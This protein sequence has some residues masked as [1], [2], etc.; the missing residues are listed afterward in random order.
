MKVVNLK[1]NHMKNPLG[2]ELETPTVS[3]QVI[4][5]HSKMQTKAQV[6]V[7]KDP[8]FTSVIFTSDANA[9]I[10]HIGYELPIS[11]EPNTRYFWRVTVW[12]NA[13]EI[14]TSE[15]AWF[16]TAKLAQ[17]WQAK[18]IESTHQSDYTPVFGK[19]VA[20]KNKPIA[21]ARAYICGLGLYELYINQ[22]KAGDEYLAPGCNAYDSWLQYQTYDITTLLTSTQNNIQVLMGDG[23][24]MGRFGFNTP[25]KTQHYGDKHQLIAEFVV[26]YTDGTQDT[27]LTD[28]SWL[29]KDSTIR[30]NSIYDGES[31]HANHESALFPCKLADQQD[32]ARLQARRSPMVRI[33]EQLSPIATSLNANGQL[34]L[35]FGQNMVG[36]V[37]INKVLPKSATLSLEF[38]EC[39]QDGDIYTENLRSAKT[40]FTYE[41]DG[42]T[43]HIRPH[44]TFF[45]F[46]YVRVTCST[47]L[48]PDAF[49][50]C[51]IY[52]DLEQTGSIETD[53]PLINQFFENVLRSQKGNFLDVPTDCPQ[54]D[55]RMGWTGDIQ[56]FAGTACY[57]MDVYAFLNKFLIDLA[58]EQAKLNGSVPFVV[59]MFDVKEAG[60]SGWGDAATVLPW[61]LWEHY[62][63]IKILKQ[64]Y[65]S[66]KTWV[67]FITAQVEK[68]NGDSYLWD[69]GF[70]FG[71]WLA[72][73]NEPN[74]KSFKGK[75]EDKFIA[76]IYFHY[77]ASIV[78]KAAEILGLKNDAIDY[79]KLSSH[80]L[81]DLR[82]EYVTK[83]GRLALDTQTGFV[84]AIMFD[85]VPAEYKD[86]VATDFVKRLKRDD[87]K[88]K[89]GFI[90]TPYMCQALTK[91]GLH[92]IAV[93]LFTNTTC[94]G[95]LYPVTKGATT[96]WERWDSVLDD[97]N[98]NPQSSMNS[99]N[100]YAFGSV[101]E[102]LYRSLFG[103]IPTNDA[104]GF[105]HVVMS[106]KPHYKFK[107]ANMRYNAIAGE[108]QIDW[109][110]TENG[111]LCFNVTVPFNCEA[112]LI[113]PD[114]KHEEINCNISLANA[115]QKQTD[116]IV[117]LNAGNYQFKY[118]PTKEY[119]K[120]YDIHVSLNQLM[121][122]SET[123][124]ILEKHIPDIIHLPFIKIMANE[125]LA[126]ISKKP[127]FKYEHSI[128]DVLNNELNQYKIN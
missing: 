5:C 31:I 58:K 30:T 71:D 22:Q 45:G 67:D 81:N 114:A 90:G 35:D 44:F 43:A 84:L 19:Q 37:E 88:I 126:D 125:S 107:K 17:P 64:Q 116:V 23:W 82:N 16:E 50:A 79:H 11:L 97:G 61:T 121:A 39:M 119:F 46:R 120:R 89:T 21:S 18:W 6:E 26:Q 117:K 85:L 72:L 12:G 7:A 102:W 49:K 80:V 59:P 110:L 47:Q 75:T 66:M 127:F 14:A 53:N 4:D 32:L 8:D 128:L 3:Y 33:Q 10:N 38:A 106:P 77:S 86:R 78:A 69:S 9:P 104:P 113:L 56:V 94:P 95:W 62:G 65:Q 60:S 74:I 52:S 87:F 112:Q 103:L 51:F 109:E 25:D 122:N 98:M 99:L 48:S 101:T 111:Q 57:N 13:D 55:E 41:S 96:I 2:F 118:F 54:R 36:W 1:T 123:N 76:S 63:D 20:L 29:V 93:D 83:T 28:T 105:K 124:Q 27:F 91:I 70:H 92:D 40:T 108:Y 15:T 100:H 24:Y 34:I 68:Q 42:V 73:D 115:L